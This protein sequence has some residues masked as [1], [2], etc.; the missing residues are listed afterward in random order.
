[1]GGILTDY[2]GPAR[3][4]TVGQLLNHTSGIP[5][6]V[7]EIP[8]LKER[9]RRSEMQRRISLRRSRPC[10]E[11]H[12]GSIWSYTNS[13]YYLLGLIIERISGK[14]TTTIYATTC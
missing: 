4:V 2:V 1:V 14:A 5:N 7:H 11:F 10:A 9:L 13:G 12:A 3:E 6:Y 8:E